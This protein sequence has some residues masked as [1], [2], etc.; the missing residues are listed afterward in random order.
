MK[1]VLYSYYRSS[2]SYRVR[3]ALAFLGKDYEYRNIHLVKDGGLQHADDYKSL[4]PMSQVPFYVD[5][6]VKLSQSIAILE[7]INSTSDNKLLSNENADS[8]K[9]RELCEVINSGIQPLQNLAVLKKLVKDFGV[10]NDQKV[11]WI[12][13]HIAN[14]FHM[15]ESLLQ[16]SNGKFCFNEFSMADALLIPQ[17]Y[18]ANRF[19]LDMS[20]FPKI[21]AI[22]EH[23]LKLDYFQKAHPNTQPDAE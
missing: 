4:N 10:S 12:K 5:G 22:N 21:S 15:V 7:Y 2:C 18:N 19:N 8:A 17:V 14:G 1:P 6:D 11:D 20:E 9:I 13:H 23:C 16:D 3:I